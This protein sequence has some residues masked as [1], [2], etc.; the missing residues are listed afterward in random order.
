MRT[1]N[2]QMPIVNLQPPPTAN[3]HQPPTTKR[4]QPSVANHQP[5]PLRT[6][7]NRQ[8]P[9]ANRQPP[10]ANHHQPPTTA[11][12]QPLFNNAS[13]VLYLADILT[14]KK[15]VSPFV[16][17]GIMTPFPLKDSPCHTGGQREDIHDS[18]IKSPRSR[19]PPYA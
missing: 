1:T 11:N 14:M 19:L 7:D 13:V 15:R 3:C 9:T 16:S 5:L 4:H 10:T 12:C 17:V 18:K 6:A 2:R 8:P